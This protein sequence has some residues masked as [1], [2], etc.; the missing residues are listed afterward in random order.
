[1]KIQRSILPQILERLKNSNKA[2]IIYGPRQ[3]G[4]TTLCND[5]ISA[6]GLK[7][8]YINADEARYVDVL[9]S[10]D[11][12]KLAEL[13]SGYE[14]LVIDEAQRIPD[15]GINLKILIDAGL[16]LKIIVTGSSSF[17]LSNKINEPLTGRHW[18]YVMYP[19]AQT[20]LHAHANKFELAQSLEERLVWGSYPELFSLN[21]AQEKAAYLRILASDYL[22][23]DIFALQEV[24]NAAKIRNLLKLLAFQIGSECSL[25]ELASALEMSK[26][27]V[28]RYIDLLE[29]TFVLFRLSGFSRNLRKEVTKTHKYYFYDLGIRNSVIDNFHPLVSRNDIGALWENFLV[30]ERLKRNAYLLKPGATYFWRTYTGAEIDYVEEREDKLAGYEFTWG[31]RERKRMPASWAAT[32]PHA[33]YTVIDRSNYLDFVL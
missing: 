21:G 22:Y 2:I 27:T 18:T 17:E 19:I 11:A 20:E 23:K 24:R 25:S 16:A 4:K 12:R 33:G 32:Y 29:K 31:A 8:F 26:E 6:A 3:V 15:I 1:M 30:I 13:V 9:T 5:I 28:M 10:R 14:L 7:T